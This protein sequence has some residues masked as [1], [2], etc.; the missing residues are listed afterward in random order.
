MPTPRHTVHTLSPRLQAVAEKV[1]LDMDA[2]WQEA[3]DADDATSEST[4]MDTVAQMRRI[5]QY[6]TAAVL[7]RLALFF[8]TQEAN[9]SHKESGQ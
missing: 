5:E 9:V 1:G 6:V 2:I 4:R 7:S 3:F 8:E